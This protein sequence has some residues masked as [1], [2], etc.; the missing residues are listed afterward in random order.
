MTAF[1][2]IDVNAWILKYKFLDHTHRSL[3]QSGREDDIDT[4]WI[5]VL[6]Y[7]HYHIKIYD[8]YPYIEWNTGNSS[9]FFSWKCAILVFILVLIMITIII[10]IINL[11]HF[12]YSLNL[13]N[14]IILMA[15]ICLQN[16]SL[17]KW[18]EFILYVT[19]MHNTRPWNFIIFD[20]LVQPASLFENNRI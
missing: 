9:I 18:E 1:N 11:M 14:S 8:S 6:I 10:I 15:E 12:S 13:L 20:I 19:D 4:Q 2:K 3:R 16:E 17:F 5:N 7:D